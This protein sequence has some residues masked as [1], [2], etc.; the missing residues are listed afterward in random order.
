ML[1]KFLIV[2]IAAVVIVSLTWSWASNVSERRRLDRW[3]RSER[4]K[5]FAKSKAKKVQEAVDVLYSEIERSEE[6]Q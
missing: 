2:S 6:E 4:T 3:A 5:R 1:I